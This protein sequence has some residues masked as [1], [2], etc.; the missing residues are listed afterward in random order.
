[1]KLTIHVG[2]DLM[3]QPKST[4]LYKSVQIIVVNRKLGH[5]FEIIFCFEKFYFIETNR[6]GKKFLLQN[7]IAISVYGLF[8]ER[9]TML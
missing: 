9:I 1:M 8:Y 7:I 6:S 3:L 2:F 4:L 5:S